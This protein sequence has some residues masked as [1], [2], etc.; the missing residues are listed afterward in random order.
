[1]KL[2]IEDR[3]NCE[4][5]TY[6]EDCSQIIGQSIRQNRIAISFRKVNIIFQ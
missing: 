6:D 5:W 4:I 1:M 2:F 3:W